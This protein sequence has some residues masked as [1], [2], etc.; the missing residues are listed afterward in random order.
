MTAMGIRKD[1]GQP[2]PLPPKNIVLEVHTA[3]N[4]NADQSGHGLSAVLRIYKLKE[5]SAFNQASME[6]LSNPESTKQALG[7]DILESKEQLL[8][9]GQRYQFN[10]KIDAKNGY[11]ALAILF[12]KPNIQRWKLIVA[13]NDLKESDPVIIGA[14][15]C[16]MNVT[17]GIQTNDSIDPKYLVAI[18]KCQN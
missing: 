15:A 2:A 11:L 9:P 14:H 12:R 8:I 13:N 1:S 4:L 18:A 3:N 6:I 10:E 16:A 17:N 7:Q 5:A